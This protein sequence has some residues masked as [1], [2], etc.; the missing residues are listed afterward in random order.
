M[1]NNILIILQ[2][3]SIKHRPQLC[4]SY[5]GNK[6]FEITSKLQFE[7]NFG[8]HKEVLNS[9]SFFESSVSQNPTILTIDSIVLFGSKWQSLLLWTLAL[10]HV[11]PASLSHVVKQWTIFH[12]TE[13]EGRAYWPGN[14]S[15]E[16]YLTI[17]LSEKQLVL[18]RGN[19]SQLA[20][21]I[22]CILRG[23]NKGIFRW[24]NLDNFEWVHIF[25]LWLIYFL[26]VNMYYNKYM[27]NY[28]EMC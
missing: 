8:A 19:V 7:K 24:L 15:R 1:H 22:K 17:G 4:T 18:F 11:L 20:G 2:N 9:V 23:C 3:F 21:Q 5:L 26:Y 6:T 14:W 12:S 13:E 28:L 25:N 27:I 16:I 10:E